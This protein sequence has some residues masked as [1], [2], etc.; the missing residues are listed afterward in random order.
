[1][2]R[3][4]EKHGYSRF[5][6]WLGLDGRNLGTV[7]SDGFDRL[8][9]GDSELSRQFGS[10]VNQFTGAHVTG[11]MQEQNEMQ[12]Q[13][14]EDQYQRQV[15]GMSNAG[16]NPALMYQGGASGSAPSAPS[17]TASG[18]L[19]DIMQV[20]MLPLQMKMMDAQ[21]KSAELDNEGKEI[22]LGFLSQ[23][24]QTALDLSSAQIDSL[25]SSLKNDKVERAL[26]RA[27][28][29]EKQ[30]NTALLVQEAVA[31]FIDN[32]TRAALNKAML[33]YRAAETAYTEQKTEES[34]KSMQ[35]A[36]AR[37]T[38]LYSRAI[39]NGAQSGYYSQAQQNLLEE[40]GILKLDK[41]T[42]QFTVDH[43]AADRTWKLAFGTVDSIGGLVRSAG[44]LI[45]VGKIGSLLKGKQAVD[46]PSG[47]YVPSSMREFGENYRIR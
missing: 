30:A 40:N 44:S 36:D 14:I 23:E 24:H 39:L 5:S 16:L 17:N 11:Q 32:D 22:D 7:L 13:N 28:I 19:S 8:M 41:H 18:S 26:K 34:K 1:M 42:K 31:E 21:I 3:Y 25:R 15:T 6:H 20:A 27:G 35:E 33:D 10:F 12:M 29:S 38:E 43:Q 2:G 47:L 46:R 37:I 4:K 45:G 9:S